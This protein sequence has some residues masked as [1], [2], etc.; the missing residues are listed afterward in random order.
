MK[1]PILMM[2]VG[3]SFFILSV[4]LRWFV[5]PTAGFAQGFL[6]GATGLLFGLSIGLN[7][8]SLRLRSRGDGGGPCALR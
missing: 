2:R 4:L 6:D 5:H 1:D 3:M 7:L 8:L